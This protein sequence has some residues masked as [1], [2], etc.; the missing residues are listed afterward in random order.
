MRSKVT[1]DAVQPGMLQTG[2]VC[3]GA[4]GIRCFAHVVV[5]ED[6]TVA[7][8]TQPMGFAPADLQSAYKIPK[9]VTGTPTIGIIDAYGYA[10]LESDLAMY[11]S[12]FGLPE[13][14]TNNGC[15]HIVNQDG[16]NA[17]LPPEAPEADDWTI[18][19][20]LDVDM[21]SAAC[22]KCKILV[23]EADDDTGT[24]LYV[25]QNT[26]ASLGASVISNSWGGPEKAGTSLDGN[27][28]YFSHDDTVAI[29]VSAGDAG[30]NDAGEGPDYPGTSAH[31][32]A[33]GGTTL[34]KAT[35]ARG[36]TEAA[37]SDGGSACSLSIE[38]PA[39]QAGSP[40]SMKAST[41]IAAVGDP[42]TGVAVY[43]AAN[44]GWTV[45]GGTSAA[46]PLVAGIWA[47]TGNGRHTSG[48]YIKDN[49]N[50][51]YD[52]TTGSNGTCGTALCTAGVGWDGP[53][54]Y[55]TPNAS[56]FAGEVSTDGGDD[57]DKDVIGGCS[58][59]HADGGLLL[60]SLALARGYTRRRTAARR[61]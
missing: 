40:C 4:S 32:I 28:A 46:A 54:G 2:A 50:R 26:A 37:W 18:E 44:G 59:A 1:L 31:V 8:A 10:N 41:D 29:F 7:S 24:G 25:A 9:T 22:P 43:H 57:D 17:P 3:G 35:N 30:F 12:Q 42:Q 56:A 58:A 5:A 14:T 20:A 16:Q 48:E 23:V 13:C 21:A 6:G 49:K 33:V 36:W 51:L 52:V 61:A 15:L 45:I 27:E 38:K 47:G 53:T 39:Y 11:R 34:A 19:T 55:G 60:I